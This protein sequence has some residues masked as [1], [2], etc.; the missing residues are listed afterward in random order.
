MIFFKVVK[1]LPCAVW[2]EIK[3]GEEG[4]QANRTV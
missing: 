3:I 4:I 2:Q 1:V